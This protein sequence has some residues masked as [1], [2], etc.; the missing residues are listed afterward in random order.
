[1]SKA[2]NILSVVCLPFHHPGTNLTF[3]KVHHTLS[4]PQG[5]KGYIKNLLNQKTLT[6]ARPAWLKLLNQL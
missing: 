5:E 2:R 1:M 6:F 4:S 3:I